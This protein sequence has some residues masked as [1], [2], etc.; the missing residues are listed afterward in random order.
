MFPTTTIDPATLQ[1][2]LETEYWVRASPPFSLLAGKPSAEL[3]DAH[4]TQGVS[5]SAFVTACNPFSQPFDHEANA[6]RQRALASEL[7][8]RDLV[9]LPGIGQHPS[10]QWP[11]EDSY[12]IFGLALESAK[13]LSTRL[14]Q[15]AF[16]WCAENAVPQLILLK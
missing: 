5:C 14:E 15:N 7:A 16:I 10:N 1:A 2:Y 12:L 3:L 6:A 8:S 13:A 9:F 4:R 11:G